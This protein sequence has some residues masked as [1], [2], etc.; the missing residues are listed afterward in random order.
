MTTRYRCTACGNLTRFD[1]TST[2]TTRAFHHFTIG[3]DLVV[4][5]EE[6]LHE[7]VHEVECRWCGHGRAIEVRDDQSPSEQAPATGSPAER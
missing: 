1:V 3:G 4:E 6:V 7:S 5:D 2:R